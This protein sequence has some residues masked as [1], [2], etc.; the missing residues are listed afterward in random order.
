MKKG[1]GER[2]KK[3]I[4]SLMRKNRQ[5]V[6]LLTVREIGEIIGLSSSSTVQFYLTQLKE[7][8]KIKKVKDKGGWRVL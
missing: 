4:L 5:L 2:Q 1:Q 8:G 7:E 3:R 6:C